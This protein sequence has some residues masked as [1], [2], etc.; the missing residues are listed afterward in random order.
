[1][2][3]ATV[4]TVA[5]L[6]A[7][8]AAE[9]ALPHAARLMMTMTAM[10]YFGRHALTLGLPRAPLG[11]LSAHLGGKVEIWARRED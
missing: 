8:G 7:V 2:R 3:P 5:V 9:I 10:D 4:A 1:M 11:R 6:S